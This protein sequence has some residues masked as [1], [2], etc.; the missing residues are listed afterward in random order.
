MPL[1]GRYYKS[2]N[3]EVVTSAI[4][5]IAV[6]AQR[7]YN[8]FKHSLGEILINHKYYITNKTD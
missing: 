8:S 7:L 4:D 2:K 6:Q 1:I 3:N 5:I